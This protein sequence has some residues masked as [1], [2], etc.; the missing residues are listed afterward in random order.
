MKKILL[1]LIASIVVV[2]AISL[3]IFFNSTQ[4]NTSSDLPDLQVILNSCEYRSYDENSGWCLF[5]A[6]FHVEPIGFSDRNQFHISYANIT[7][8]N[9][10]SY[11][12]FHPIRNT[13]AED[14]TYWLDFSLTE[15]IE[16]VELSITFSIQETDLT[17]SIDLAVPLFSRTF[18][19]YPVIPPDVIEAKN[20]AIEQ[21]ANVQIQL[22]YNSS[23]SNYDRVN[24]TLFSPTSG[25]GTLE[26][27]FSYNN[28]T[29]GG[30]ASTFNGIYLEKGENTLVLPY[31][32]LCNTF[33][34][35]ED[36]YLYI[37]HY[38]DLLESGI[39]AFGLMPQIT[40]EDISNH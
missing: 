28:F 9:E 8:G 2:S 36:G 21:I 19:L 25:N 20:D 27:Y 33:S 31:P 11:G 34:D 10:R 16:P 30:R 26:I 5:T 40:Y 35:Y 17:G 37:R 38:N 1:I 12:E 15:V 24:L 29:E 3:P 13:N 22:L 23:I 32:N 18:R 7:D 4:N 39:L 6:I 14:Y